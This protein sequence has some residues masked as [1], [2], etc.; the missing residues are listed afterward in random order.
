MPGGCRPAP[1]YLE[2]DPSTLH[3]IFARA[4]AQDHPAQGKPQTMRNIVVLN[5]PCRE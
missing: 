4:A 5:S 3:K 2:G 1:A